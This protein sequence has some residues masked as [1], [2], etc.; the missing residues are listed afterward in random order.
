MGF[1]VHACIYECKKPRNSRGNK[2]AFLQHCFGHVILCY[3]IMIVA[4]LCFLPS[5]HFLPFSISFM[6]HEDHRAG[7]F[8]VYWVGFNESFFVDLSE[9]SEP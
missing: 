4:D 1:V 9:K 3:A 7:S 6:D 2:L 5:S 8:R